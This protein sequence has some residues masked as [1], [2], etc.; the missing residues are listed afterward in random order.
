[1][2]LLLSDTPVAG[3]VVRLAHWIGK[4]TGI[5]CHAMVKR[6]YPHNAFNLPSGA[7]GSLPNWEK[8]LIKCIG[9][10]NTLIIHNVCDEKLMDL[11]FS[12]KKSSA[13]VIYQYHSP[14]ME[15]PQFDYAT[16]NKYKFDAILAVAQGYSRFIENAIPVPNIIADFKSPLEIVKT[17]SIF[18]PHMR[19]TGYRW[20]E[21][22]TN[23]DKNML[24]SAQKF[25][26]DF[27]LSEIKKIFNRDVVSHEEILLYLQSTSVVVDDINTG[28]FHQTAL[29]AV[30]AGCV[31][32]S[33]ADLY[34][35][36][37]FCIAAQAPAPPFISVS[38]IDE[39]IKILIDPS[40]SKSLDKKR[41][42]SSHYADK[43]LGEERLAN[44]YF[45]ILK[46][47]APQLQ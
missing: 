24:D 12:A 30:K 28:L 23:T 22:F 37:D 13:C 26:A 46:K 31:V 44:C 18:V 6:N 9:K 17:K 43:F 15:P 29:E 14:P 34:A 38:G 20:S 45:D 27:Q 16:I 33:A 4:L 42:V 1:M 41:Q 2:I 36:E 39:V 8:T 35:L 11:I 7:F 25:M 10:S 21:K 3:T 32:F 47:Y 5:E 19:S 40:F